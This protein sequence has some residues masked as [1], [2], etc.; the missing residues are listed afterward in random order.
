M[1][2]SRAR[3]LP[4]LF[5]AA[6]VLAAAPAAAQGGPGPGRTDSRQVTLD[7]VGG[8]LCATV[9]PDPATVWRPGKPNKIRK[10]DWVVV[11]EE[12]LYWEIRYA[13]EKP[14]AEED[15]FATS[16]PIDVPCGDNLFRTR[17]PKDP[18]RDGARWPYEIRVYA[19]ADG[20]KGELL[21]VKDP[22]IDWGT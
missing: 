17:P 4:L 16:A 2:A 12:D 10:V 7:Y 11:D 6:T 20:A 8:E 18:G 5:L 3:S 1:N 15:Y 13:P 19:C 9:F 22:E 14:G 21:C